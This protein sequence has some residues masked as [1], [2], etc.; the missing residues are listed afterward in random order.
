MW[1]QVTQQC[2]NEVFTLE[3]LLNKFLKRH[4]ILLVAS[5][6]TAKTGCHLCVPQYLSAYIHFM[7]NTNTHTDEIYYQAIF[8][9]SLPVKYIW[10]CVLSKLLLVRATTVCGLAHAP[11]RRSWEGEWELKSSHL[12]LVRELLHQRA[13]LAGRGAF[14]NS[15]QDPL[16]TT[17]GLDRKSLHYVQS[18]SS[19]QSVIKQINTYQL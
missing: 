6:T 12:P 8:P 9:I 11:N 17:G 2:H 16:V 10:L 14:L 4:V 15:P 18:Q 1:P 5:F 7:Q 3:K 13:C 19:S